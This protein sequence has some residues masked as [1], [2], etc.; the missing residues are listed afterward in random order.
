MDEYVYDTSYF[1]NADQTE[2]FRIQIIQDRDCESPRY[3]TDCNAAVLY[4]ED[5]SY[6]TPD[7]QDNLPDNVIFA[8]EGEI[9]ARA[10]HIA[11]TLDPEVLAWGWLARGGQGDLILDLDDDGYGGWG[12]SNGEGIERGIATVTVASYRK[13]MVLPGE[14]LP[15]RSVMVEWA[16]AAIKSEVY[17]YSMW[18][19]GE[20]Y[21]YVISKYDGATED[22]EETDDTCW[23]Y[24]GVEHAVEQACAC[25]PDDLTEVNEPAT[26]L[27]GTIQD[28]H[29]D[30]VEAELVNE[31]TEK[32]AKFATLHALII[33]RDY[34]A[35]LAKAVFMIPDFPDYVI[36]MSRLDQIRQ[37]IAAESVS[38]GELIELADLADYID[39]GDLELL[40]W[41]GVPEHADDDTE[42]N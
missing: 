35:A 20:C 19:S 4:C 39:P 24:I 13:C 23:G 17:E 27:I 2:L 36:K 7:G 11:L 37:A 25:L 21:G 8:Y 40:Q 28:A 26:L 15:E 9:R 29:D 33:D 6:H 22:W 14:E 38:Q 12:P 34:T 5:G 32:L 18:A 41:A 16:K 3:T 10:T 42:E 30:A 31:R 1:T